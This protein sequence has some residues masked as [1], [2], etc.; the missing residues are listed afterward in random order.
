MSKLEDSQKLYGD[1]LREEEEWLRKIENW[2]VSLFLGGIALLGKQLI[3]WDH[4]ADPSKALS[5]QPSIFTLPAVVGVVAFIF[6]RLVNY[7]GHDVYGKLHILAGQSPGT[8]SS[9]ISFGFM[10]L[11]MAVMPLA[12]GYGVSWYLSIAHQDRRDLFSSVLCWG[13]VILVVTL[14]AHS[15]DRREFFKRLCRVSKSKR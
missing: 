12:L 6:L 7:R 4:P 9:R 11:F 3:E 10:P 13:G 1:F 15:W 5:L 8:G 14:L 2:G